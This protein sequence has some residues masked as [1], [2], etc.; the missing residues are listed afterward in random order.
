MNELRLGEHLFT[1]QGVTISP[2]TVR[3]L[4]SLSPVHL[5]RLLA[6][7]VHECQPAGG[8]LRKIWCEDVVLSVVRQFWAAVI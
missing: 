7:G 5:H 1:W 8:E 4:V 6:I 3:S 2:G